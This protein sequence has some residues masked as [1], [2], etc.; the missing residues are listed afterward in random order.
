[1]YIRVISYI[2]PS[3]P[4]L[5]RPPPP[6]PPFPFPPRSTNHA[7]HTLYYTVS[8]SWTKVLL[9][10]GTTY[11]LSWLF[12]ACM[13]YSYNQLDKFYH[14]RHVNI[15]GN[16]SVVVS[17]TCVDKLEKFNSAMEFAIETSSTIGYGNIYVDPTCHIGVLFLIFQ[18]L[19][20]RLID[21][22]W[23]GLVFLKLARP[24]KRMNT[25]RF[26]KRSAIS[27]LDGEQRLMFRIGDLN[28]GL[29]WASTELKLYMF[30]DGMTKEGVHSSFRQVRLDLDVDS[31]LFVLPLVVSHIITDD[32]PLWGMTQKE[33]ATKKVEFILVFEGVV[34]A[35]G[36]TLHARTSYVN[37]EIR[38]GQFF[39][40]VNFRD[41]KGEARVDWTLFDETI[42]CATFNVSERVCLSSMHPRVVLLI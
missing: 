42:P 9:L 39:A 41:E 1:M 20:A 12:W 21:C 4:V 31:V 29:N 23:I 22:F 33:M 36:N 17:G 3:S 34:E 35:T 19:L 40:E 13:W 28:P 8:A 10:F 32:S 38:W 2:P 27:V 30:Y 37:K 15:T 26:S 14:N 7:C 16:G 6:P 24:E 11:A 18:E 5:P 25:M